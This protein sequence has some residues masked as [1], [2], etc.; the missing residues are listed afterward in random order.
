MLTTAPQLVITLIRRTGTTQIAAYRQHLRT[1]VW[2]Y[3]K[4]RPYHLRPA[5]E[6]AT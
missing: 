1:C 6:H 4:Q 3:V 2:G 5:A